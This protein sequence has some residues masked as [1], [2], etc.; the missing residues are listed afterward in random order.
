MGLDRDVS[1]GAVG[2]RGP[3][4][5]RALVEAGGF[6]VRDGHGRGPVAALE[7]ETAGRD[8]TDDRTSPCGHGDREGF[9]RDLEVHPPGARRDSVA[10]AVYVGEVARRCPQRTGRLRDRGIAATRAGL[11]RVV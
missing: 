5:K 4:T 7:E 10:V 3:Q 1:G 11:A 8:L 6:G 2:E 9:E